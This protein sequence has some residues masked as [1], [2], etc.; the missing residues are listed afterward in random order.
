MMTRMYE[1]QGA[2]VG[3]GKW[4]VAALGVMDDWNQ[5]AAKV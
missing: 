2:C 1:K 3:G 5:I 4:K